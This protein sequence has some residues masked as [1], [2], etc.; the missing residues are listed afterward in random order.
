MTQPDFS[1]AA[2]MWLRVL[3]SRLSSGGDDIMLAASLLS[4]LSWGF[5]LSTGGWIAAVAEANTVWS[6]SSVGPFDKMTARSR[7]FSSSRTFPG[8]V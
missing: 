3:D 6:I 1:S 2:R 4:S 5:A 8:H 7:T